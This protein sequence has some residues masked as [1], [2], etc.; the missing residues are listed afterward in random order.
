MPASHTNAAKKPDEPGGAGR[1]LTILPGVGLV[2]LDGVEKG[3]LVE[4]LAGKVGDQ[5]ELFASR[6]REGLLAASVAIGLDVMGELMATEVTEL[7]GPKGKH[8]SCGR[9]AYRHGG[10]DGGVVVGGR[11]LPVRRPRVRGVDG[12][13]VHLESY[14]TFPAVDLLAE[15]TVAAMLAGLSTRRYGDALEPVGAAVE[16]QACS[17]SR[18]AVSRRF[19]AATRGGPTSAPRPV[20]PA[21]ADLLHRRVRFRRSHHGRRARGNQR[22]RRYRWAWWK[23]RRGTAPLYVGWSAACATGGLT[24]DDGILFVLD[25]GKALRR[26]VKD[27]YGDRALVQRCR[28]H[29]ERNILDHLPARE[30]AWVQAKLRRAWTNPDADEARRDLETLARQLD[31]VNPDA[32]GSLREGLPEMFTVT[33]LKVTG[34]LLRDRLIVEPGRVDDRDRPES[35]PQREELA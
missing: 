28:I 18:S 33:R 3:Q 26:A 32:A 17:T 13:E 6:M 10:V 5:L 20:R 11:R 35:Q 23:A 25:G 19:R 27:V 21:V 34:A 4:R 22:R 12:Q 15:H 29:K 31:K 8:N 30:R 16:E 1:R 9:F 24:A 2:D 14:D 7:A